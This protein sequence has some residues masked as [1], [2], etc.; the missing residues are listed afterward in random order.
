M[1][2]I[3][4]QLD[5][6]N[7]NHINDEDSDYMTLQ[8]DDSTNG[9]SECVILQSDYINGANREELLMLFWLV[10]FSACQQGRIVKIKNR[11]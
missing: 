6:I 4:R 8:P 7:N 3:I 5:E 11:D 10:I 1:T 9:N 2:I